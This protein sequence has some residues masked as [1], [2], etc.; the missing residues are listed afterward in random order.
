M[1]MKKLHLKSDP[2]NKQIKNLSQFIDFYSEDECSE[3][4]NE[5]NRINANDFIDY[6]KQNQ[7]KFY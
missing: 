3:K 1:N 6:T 7:A 5:I 4:D 2:V